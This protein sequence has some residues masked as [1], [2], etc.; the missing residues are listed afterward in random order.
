V[1]LARA[2]LLTGLLAGC[3]GAPRTPEALRPTAQAAFPNSPSP[4]PAS[5]PTLPAAPVPVL[6]S[7]RTPHDASAPAL[8]ATDVAIQGAGRQGEPATH[9][10]D[11]ASLLPAIALEAGLYRCDLKR[12][13]TVRRVAIDRRSIVIN[14]LGKDTDLQSVSTNSGALRFENTGIGLVWIVIP[15]KSMLLDSRIGRT[16]ANECRI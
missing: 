1:P 8:P 11:A 6:S 12:R 9:Q 13:V 2:L 5:A 16:L 14:W 10:T 4:L 15:S 3:A 7:D